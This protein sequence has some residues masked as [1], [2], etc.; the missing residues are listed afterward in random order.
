MVVF[1][2]VDPAPGVHREGDPVQT[3]VADGTAEAAGVVGL[4][5]GLQDLSENAT[6]HQI[7]KASRKHTL[8]FSGPK[9]QTRIRMDPGNVFRDPIGFE[10]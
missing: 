10:N 1:D 6:E 7:P 9:W 8:V 4:P 5:Q 2:A 3:L